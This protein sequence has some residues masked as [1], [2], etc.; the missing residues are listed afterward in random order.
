MAYRAVEAALIIAVGPSVEL[1]IALARI[2][3]WVMARRQAMT[4]KFTNN[5][6]ASCSCRLGILLLIIFGIVFGPANRATGQCQSDK[7]LASDGEEYDQFGRL[8]DFNQDLAIIGASQDDVNGVEDAGS[9]YI[10][11]FNGFEWIQQFKLTASDPGMDHHFGESVAIE[12]DI[13]VMGAVGDDMGSAYVFRFDG[14]NWAEV[15]KLK[16][17]DATLGMAFGRAFISG[18]TILVTAAL[19]DHVDPDDLNCNAGSAYIFRNNG[20]KWIEETKLTASDA[21]CHSSFGISGDIDGSTVIIGAYVDDE[22][23]P[24]AGAAY[25]FN[26]NGAEWVEHRKLIPIDAQTSMSFGTSVAISEDLIVVGAPGDD[27]VATNSGAV[28]IYRLIGSKWI[29]EAKLTAFD[30]SSE[31]LFGH[32]VAIDGD[33]ICVSAVTHTNGL[34]N[35]GSAYIFIRNEKE[36][37]M[38]AKLTADIPTIADY[39]GSAVAVRGTT[40]MVSSV[41]DDDNG[42]N[43]GSV[44]VFDLDAPIGDLD[45]SG[46]VGTSDLLILLSSW[47]PCDDCNNCVADL[48]DDCFVGTSDLLILLSNWG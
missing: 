9:A 45:C 6:D 29:E 40:A 19:D 39:F 34:S 7:L 46:S 28:Y 37:D 18:E 36:W 24:N 48:N 26:F 1:C 43:S 21:M 14:A 32:S 44:F 15:T 17:S 33:V 11:W 42:T 12:G 4:M 23:G 30:G 10:F 8:I 22:A 25:I 47:G 3:A 27:D 41:W 20:S 2:P 13:A 16:A 31:D 5:S 38:I 35:T